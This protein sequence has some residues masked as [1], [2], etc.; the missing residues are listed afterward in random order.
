MDFIFFLFLLINSLFIINS[1]KKADIVV[2][3]TN[4]KV[5]HSCSNDVYQFQFDVTFSN[6]FDEIIPF[7]LVLPLPN[8]FPFKCIIDGPKSNIE[9]FHS[10]SNYVWALYT[11]SKIELPYSFPEIEGIKWDYDSFLK[12][13]SRY[14]WINDR[15]CGLVNIFDSNANNINSQVSNNQNNIKESK[16]E[17]TFDVEKIDGGECN[18]SKNDYS[19]KMKLKLIEG[20]LFEELK[21]SKKNNNTLE[22]S[23]LQSIYVPILI[24]DK[25][26]KGKTIFEGN[27]EYKYAKCYNEFGITQN[28]FDSNEGLNFICH[29]SI[30]KYYNFQGPVQ[31]KP[32]T[33]YIYIKKNE[34]EEKIDIKKIGIKFEIL[35]GF[36]ISESSDI[37]S[38]NTNLKIKGTP[39]E[40]LIGGKIPNIKEPNF[41]ILDSKMNTFIC[42]NTPILT[43]KDYNDGIQFGGLNGLGTKYLF[44]IYGYLTNGF[45]YVNDTISLLDRT[46]D[47]IRFRL[48]VVDNLKNYENRRNTIKCHIPSGSSIN[49]NELIEVKCIG[50]RV[51]LFNNNTDIILNWNIEENNNLKNIVVRWPYDLTK[52]KHIFYYEIQGLSVKKDNYGCFENKYYFYLYVFDLKSEPKISFNLPLISPKNSHAECKLYNSV[53]FKCIIDLRLK[54][55]F[56]GEKIILPSNFS[57]YLPNKENNYVYYKVDNNAISS[58][59][60]FQLLVEENCGDFKLIGALKDIGYTYWQALIII[61]CI[62]VFLILCT[63]CVIFV[64]YYEITHR[65]KKGIYFKH[66]EET[67]I[68]NVSTTSIGAQQ[69]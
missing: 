21:T 61:I 11:N 31:I 33:D 69:K 30:N 20:E 54:R 66:Y 1:Q 64:I 45:E 55:L 57:D 13:I 15:H 62:I 9:C 38:S 48:K 32:F 12:K 41:L 36:K 50:D 2:Y 4:N 16:A 6:K 17:M 67:K 51:P 68:P 35:S 7:E 43:I 47:E 65:N 58:P 24:G 10:F 52:K 60:D 5:I 19:F 53:T 29:L 39:V 26:L 37:I 28:N 3:P 42:P 14:L 44:L 59:L 23:F 27:N 8:N 46:K 34:T 63:I 40:K 18:S 49:Q 22:I 25:A 56:K